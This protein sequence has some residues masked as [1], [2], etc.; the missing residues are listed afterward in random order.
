[1]VRG[2]GWGP[3]GGARGCSLV[4]NCGGCPR[5]CGQT[6]PPDSVPCTLHPT[7]H[8]P[9]PYPT[10]QHP[11]SGTTS[12]F[13]HPT[14]N[15]LSSPTPHILYLHPAP[16]ISGPHTLASCIPT[17][18]TFTQVVDSARLCSEAGGGPLR[19]EEL[20]G[21]VVNTLVT[22]LSPPGASVDLGVLALQGTLFLLSHNHTQTDTGGNAWYPHAITPL[23]SPILSQECPGEAQGLP[24]S[25]A[26]VP[27]LQP[28]CQAASGGFRELGWKHYGAYCVWGRSS[29]ALMDEGVC[30]LPGSWH[31]QSVCDP[32]VKGA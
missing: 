29:S 11:A 31:T 18:Y 5:T 22:L 4:P 30:S 23:P 17:P 24:T 2:W 28:E 7:P 21:I 14:A 12:S 1:M 19:H 3:A 6:S 9:Q 8:N 32:N 13:P 26:A 10:A 25:K 15:H 20:V 27:S 16:H